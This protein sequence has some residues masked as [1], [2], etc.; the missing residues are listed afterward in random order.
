MDSSLP[1]AS[2]AGSRGKPLNKSMNIPKVRKPKYQ[3]QTIDSEI[4]YK[5]EDVKRAMVKMN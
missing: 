4:D 3:S 5:R 1:R 2:R